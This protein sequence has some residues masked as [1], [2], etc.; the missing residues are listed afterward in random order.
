[1]CGLNLHTLN[2]HKHTLQS[3]CCCFLWQCWP[4]QNC[5][6][7]FTVS[8]QFPTRKRST[9]TRSHTHAHTHTRTHTHTHTHT[10]AHTHT[11]TR[12][13]TRT[14]THTRLHQAEDVKG[15]SRHSMVPVSEFMIFR[16][17]LS[18]DLQFPV[19]REWTRERETQTKTVWRAVEVN[20]FSTEILQTMQTEMPLHTS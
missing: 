14:H 3:S 7:I 15:S 9:Q 1:M 19:H 13:R 10:H 11:R 6:R 12:T 8:F 4:S 18:I 5:S 17:N 20:V 16:S 2:L